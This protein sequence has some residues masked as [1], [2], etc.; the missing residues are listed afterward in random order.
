MKKYRTLLMLL[1]FPAIA[2]QNNRVHYTDKLPAATRNR[3]IENRIYKPA[4]L[5]DSLVWAVDSAGAGSKRI[6]L[7]QRK[8]A[9]C[10]SALC[11]DLTVMDVAKNKLLFHRTF[12]LQQTRDLRVFYRKPGLAVVEYFDASADQSR[13]Y[14]I[15]AGKPAVY[16]T[17]RVSA[18]YLFKPREIDSNRMTY[19]LF[20]MQEKFPMTKKWQPVR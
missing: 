8:D 13:Y 10:P 20:S 15:L 6:W 9:G 18:L 12:P 5:A 3:L 19:V 14:L 16:R 17:G 11:G 2:C 7:I 4:Q 1:V